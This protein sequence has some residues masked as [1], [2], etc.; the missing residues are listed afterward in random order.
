MLKK[1]ANTDINTDTFG[2]PCE[3]NKQS[4]TDSK[5]VFNNLNKYFLWDAFYLLQQKLT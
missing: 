2:I 4:A 5:Q 3:K 1:S